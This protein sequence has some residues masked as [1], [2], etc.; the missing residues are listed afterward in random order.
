[1]NGGRVACALCGAAVVVGVLPSVG[2]AQGTPTQLICQSYLARADCT[3]VPGGWPGGAAVTFVA[4]CTEYCGQGADMKE[5]GTGEKVAVPVLAMETA[6]AQPVAGAF[7]QVGHC[8]GLPLFSFAGALAAG[9]SYNVVGAFGAPHGRVKLLSFK[10][11]NSV[12]SGDGG[13][14]P[15]G[16]DGGAVPP[17]SD[18]GAVLPGSDGGTVPG[19]SDGGTTPARRDG[20]ATP[21]GAPEGGCGCGAAG[22]GVPAGLALVGLVFL[23]VLLRRRAG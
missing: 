18:G 19:H 11:A 12:G 20:G 16:S 23:C 13:A 7:A 22:D 21:G 1:M 3:E 14:V 2:F 8:I 9:A 6:A 17:G 15:P 10:V 4:S 5:C